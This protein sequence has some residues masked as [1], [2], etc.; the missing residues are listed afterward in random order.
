MILFSQLSLLVVGLLLLGVS[1]F[2]ERRPAFRP[3]IFVI[4]MFFAKVALPLLLLA[5]F[6]EVSRP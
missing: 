3:R 6:A 5:L 4:P 1:V 2:V